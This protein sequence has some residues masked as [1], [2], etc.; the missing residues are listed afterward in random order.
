MAG[1]STP[2]PRASW[3]LG[4]AL[5][6]AGRPDDALAQYAKSLAIAP[7]HAQTLF[8]VGVVRADGKGDFAGAITSWNALLQSHPDYT[9]AA[10]VRTL[11]E[12]ARTKLRG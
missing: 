10:R 3:D 5:W 1:S 11:I 8:N 2:S 4:T 7:T 6:Y 9:D 12:D